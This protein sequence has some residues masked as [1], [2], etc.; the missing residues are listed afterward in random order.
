METP[1]FLFW[2]H[3][4]KLEPAK[5]NLYRPIKSIQSMIDTFLPA[6]LAPDRPDDLILIGTFHT[7]RKTKTRPHYT[8]PSERL[9]YLDLANYYGYRRILFII[10]Y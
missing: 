2:Q 8:R 1:K 6:Y 5:D 10:K 7:M 9:L 4:W 3:P